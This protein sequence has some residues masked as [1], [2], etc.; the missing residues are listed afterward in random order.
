LLESDFLNHFV[1]AKIVKDGKGEKLYDIGF[2]YQIQ[3]KYIE[4]TDV[5][6]RNG[7]RLIP[8]SVIIFLPFSFLHPLM[9]YKYF[10]YT[11]YIILVLT[12]VWLSIQFRDLVR[13]KPFLGLI[14]I[15]FLPVL[16]SLRMGQTSVILLLLYAS[17]YF[18]L[19]KKKWFLLGFFTSFFLLKIQYLT[20]FPFLFIL[21]EDKKSYLKGF[22]ISMLLI[23]SVSLYISGWQTLQKYPEFVLSS[24]IPKLGS[25]AALSFTFY[26]FL[27]AQN[28][29]SKMPREF[30]IAA[31]LIFYLLALVIFRYRYKEVDREK[32]FISAVLFSI[33]F[34]MHTLAHDLTVTLIPIFIILNLVFL[35]K[36]KRKYVSQIIVFFLFFLPSIIFLNTTYFLQFAFLMVGLFFL[37]PG[38]RSHEEN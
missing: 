1:A 7:F 26:G 2:N 35:K 19:K 15:V 37:F 28:M 8:A 4:R 36:E 30:L 33:F 20:L 5:R 6:N 23:L 12:S 10:V 27:L 21:S 17:L 32:S 11:N 31:N 13:G 38:S 16:L 29:I 34:S 25:N 14:P 22:F 3:E 9:A 24:E 18:L